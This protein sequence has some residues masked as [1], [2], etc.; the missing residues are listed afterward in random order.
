MEQMTLY[1][2]ILAY[3]ARHDVYQ[4]VGIF[5]NRSSVGARPGIGSLGNRLEPSP[6][7]YLGS[8]SPIFGIL[9]S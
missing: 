7:V 4:W 9:G 3:F 8:E 1:R 6:V 2:S 5:A